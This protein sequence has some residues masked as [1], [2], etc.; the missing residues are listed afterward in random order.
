MKRLWVLVVAGL[1]ASPPAIA[2][3]SSPTPTSDNT[4]IAAAVDSEG[5]VQAPEESLED[6]LALIAAT[7]GWTIQQA[8]TNHATAESIGK[9]TQAIFSERPDILVGAK[10]SNDPEG[11]PTLYVKGN[12]GPYVLDL[13]TKSG[14]DV[15]VADGQTFSIAELE[16]RKLRV[17]QS[18]TTMGFQNFAVSFDITA[19]GLISAGVYGPPGVSTK[20]ADILSKLPADIRA[21]VLLMVHDGPVVTDH[22]SF[23]GMW[24]LMNGVNKCTSGFSVRRIATTT[25]G[26]LTAGHCT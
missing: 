1:L 14:I 4:A 26:I 18:L 19:A 3:A 11:P 9:I 17:A 15:V 13:I 25:Y 12:A 6:D 23:G 24:M 10:L 7:R 8:R 2:E 21:D 16:A 5:S 20:P 22:S